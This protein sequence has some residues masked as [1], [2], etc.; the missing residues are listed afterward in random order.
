MTQWNLHIAKGQGTAKI[1]S[2]RYNE[3]S[4]YGGSFSYV[5]LLLELRRSFVIPRTLLYRGSLY[6]GSAV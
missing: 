6:R 1:C 5:L 3:V 4:L 2:V